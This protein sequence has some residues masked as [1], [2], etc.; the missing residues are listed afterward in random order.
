MRFKQLGLSN[1]TNFNWTALDEQSK[2]DEAVLE[3]SVQ[4]KAGTFLELYQIV[5]ECGGRTIRT[6]IFNPQEFSP[7]VETE[8]AAVELSAGNDVRN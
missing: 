2:L 3:G 8:V 5:G 1:S 6:S 4:A 7:E